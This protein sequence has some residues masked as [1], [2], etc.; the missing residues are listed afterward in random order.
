[1]CRWGYP[2][3]PEGERDSHAQ[4]YPVHRDT[5]RQLEESAHLERKGFN[6]GGLTPKYRA[7][8][9]EASYRGCVV[10]WV[11]SREIDCGIQRGKSRL[12]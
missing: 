3:A 10:P 11:I 2:F 12:N 7:A 6:L 8:S 4:R 9:I 5:T 1:M